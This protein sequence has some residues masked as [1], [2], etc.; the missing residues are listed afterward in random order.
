V[1]GEVAGRAMPDLVVRG[2]IAC[3][4]DLRSSTVV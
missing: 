4:S 2:C 3:L 1:E